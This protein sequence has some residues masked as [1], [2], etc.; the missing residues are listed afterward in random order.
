MVFIGFGFGDPDLQNLLRRMTRIV[1]PGFPSFA[2]L[3][4]TDSSKRKRMKREYNIEVIPYSVNNGDH[5][6]LLEVLRAH[7][8]FIVTRDIQYGSRSL[9][10]VG[11][12]PCVTSLLVQNEIQKKA[13]TGTSEA[14]YII[15]RAS[16]LSALGSRDELLIT[17][18]VEDIKSRCGPKA[19][20]LVP[21]A[22]SELESKD[23]IAKSDESA[24]LSGQ[25]RDLVSSGSAAAELQ[26]DQF[27]ASLR[28]RIDN[29]RDSE[30]KE[31]I[32][33][34]A[35]EFLEKIC[36]DRGL[37]VAQNLVGS[38]P[39]YKKHRAVAL[40]QELPKCFVKCSDR[41]EVLL[42]VN[43]VSELL[44]MPME[45]EKVYLGLLTQAYFGK[46]LAGADIESA[47]LRREVLDTTLFICDSS[48]LISFLA[49]ESTGHTAARTLIELLSIT[50]SKPI[51]TD[52]LVTETS[53]H[54]EYA[55][56]LIKNKGE[57]SV[58]VLN[59]VLSDDNAF[60][61]GY[62]TGGGMAS[63]QRFVS[64]IA[65]A[66]GG[67]GNLHGCVTVQLKKLGIEMLPVAEWDGFSYN[68]YGDIEHVKQD[69]ETRRR[70]LNT[71]KHAR[72]VEAEAVVAVLISKIRQHKL[73]YPKHPSENAFFFESQPR[74][75]QYPKLTAH[76]DVNDPGVAF[77]M[78]KL[79]P[80]DVR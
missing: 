5:S 61:N 67:T 26:R 40:L 38:H 32:V 63:G 34:I 74:N 7:S 23:L 30:Q 21:Q 39:N 3:H 70:K 33:Q 24:W 10:G 35:S 42:L 76:T 12:D 78:A 80:R 51:T 29:Q 75:R 17:E 71:F 73:K 2:F 18:L 53:E 55:L 22:V 15:T 31:R 79:C 20:S 37:G 65:D 13:L 64:Y 47:P 11:Y 54:A 25:G 9:E 45:S 66:L 36:R 19:A 59:E 58:D 8:S 6:D 49:K 62:F 69:I 60:L 52:L 1:S 16:I 46:H 41:E 72:Q 68:L 48:F 28:S 27:L 56:R 50:Q 4:S 44:Q 43:V 14:P 77:P 57:N